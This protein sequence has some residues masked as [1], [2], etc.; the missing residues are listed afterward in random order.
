MDDGPYLD[1]VAAIADL[2]RSLDGRRPL[3]GRALEALARWYD[4]EMTYSSNA[5]EGNTLTLSETQIV[6]EKGLAVGGKPVKDHVEALD[7]YSATKSM[8]AMAAREVP[9]T[10][11]TVLD[12]H[13]IV[14][15]RSAPGIAGRYADMPRRVAGSMVIF[16]RAEKVPAL[17]EKLG[18]TLQQASGWESAFEAH[19]DLVSIHPFNDGNG[20]TARLL[21]NLLLIKDGFPPISIRPEHRVEYIRTLQERQ[22]AEPL[23]HG[24]SDAAARRAYRGFL[25]Q[26]LVASLEDH[27][28]FIRDEG[29]APGRDGTG[30]EEHPDDAGRLAQDRARHAGGDETSRGDKGIRGARPEGRGGRD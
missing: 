13:A 5:I 14:M 8:R 3:A 7:L 23:G 27:L 25:G 30:N 20:R 16:P 29:M 15:H 4:V 12:L 18:R 22:M 17:M 24:L 9:A 28:E 2:K 11:K 6:V 1:Q 10:E 19:F 21:L 26:R